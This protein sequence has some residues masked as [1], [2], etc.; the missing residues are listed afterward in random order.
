[1]KG[2]L[3]LAWRYLA[4]HRLK[5]VI[6][7]G[8]IT[9]ILYLPV[10]L[11]VLVDQSSAQL[12]AR[13]QAT[14]LIIGAKGSPLELVLN[15]LYFSDDR[16]AR[17]NYGE[18]GRVAESGL[19]TAIPAYVRFRARGY[20]I[21]GTTLDYFSFRK[22]RIAAGRQMATLGECVLGARAA[23][24]MGI[25]PG[26]AVVSSPESVF[27]LAGVYPLKMTVTGLL[28]FSDGPDDDAVFVDLKTAWIIEGLGHG[29][30]D[31]AKPE[32]AGGVLS[33]EGSKVVANASVVQYN[34]ITADNID[35]FHFH[36]DL[37]GNPI[38]AVIV[39]PPDQKASALL[40]GRYQ[41][42]EERVQIVAPSTVIDELLGTILTV[43]SFIMAGAVILG[44]ATL[45]TT[46]LVFLLSLRLRR[47]ERVTLFKIGGSR[48][49]V[50]GIMASEIV[51]VLVLGGLL[52]ASLTL[53]TDQF[54][55][56]AIRAVI[57]NWG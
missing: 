25:G 28:A 22:L 11:R 51:A 15:T 4:Y 14:P 17:M 52:A 50:A 24:A 32:A 57:R 40:Q 53:L 20:P 31:L 38:T 1:V 56:V 26:D 19:A 16:P 8:S 49:G 35:S 46:V 9:L 55:A 13:A 18:A 37:S 29:H 47:R 45:A 48:S 7:V 44:L 39:M 30:Q 34:E 36:G 27:D 10:G 2:I 33:R 43:R 41:S 3:Y 6:L 23:G 42:D 5:T 12:T 54:G 21:V